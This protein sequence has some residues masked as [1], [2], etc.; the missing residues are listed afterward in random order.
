[1]QHL[2]KVYYAVLSSDNSIVDIYITGG[3]IKASLHVEIEHGCAVLYDDI[4]HTMTPIPTAFKALSFGPFIYDE[5]ENSLTVE[6]TMINQEVAI[7]SSTL[8]ELVDR[9]EQCE[10]KPSKKPFIEEYATKYDLAEETKRRRYNDDKILSLIGDIKEGRNSLASQIEML[11]SVVAAEISR[12]KNKDNCQDEG[13]DK[14]RCDVNAL[15]RKLDENTNETT[16]LIKDESDA[17]TNALNEVYTLIERLR[18]EDTNLF[19]RIERVSDELR[20]EVKRAEDAERQLHHEIHHEHD[21]RI[22]EEKKLYD[23]IRVIETEVRNGDDKLHREIHHEYNRAKREEDSLLMSIKRE[24]EERLAENEEMVK[25]VYKYIDDKLAQLS[26]SIEAIKEE[27][28]D[29]KKNIPPSSD[30]DVVAED[31]AEG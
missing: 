2:K 27:L 11:E 19:K 25:C 13:L 10:K 29:I 17:R 20:R 14:I 15:K 21:E 9:G 4:K 5:E 7:F 26:L 24:R 12:S 28:E 23:L 3:S 8:N 1:M 22:K 6:I 30:S 16:K 31:G 18:T